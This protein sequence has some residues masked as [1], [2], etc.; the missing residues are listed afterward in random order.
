MV[1]KLSSQ[2]LQVTYARDGK[3]DGTIDVK[4][5]GVLFTSIP[6]DQ[7]WTV[8]VDGKKVQTE[9]AGDTFLALRL[10]AGH[11]EVKMRYV[12]PGFKTGLLISAACWAFFL[13]LC[14][15]WKKRRRL[16]EKKK[17]TAS[18]V[19]GDSQDMV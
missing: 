16:Y 8:E 4:E 9:K 13:L 15:I 18:P 7:G 19:P 14:H 2:G 17:E 10:G 3:L 1:E 12:S 6:Y 11:H 5:D